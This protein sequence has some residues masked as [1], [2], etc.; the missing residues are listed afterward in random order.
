[1]IHREVRSVLHLE[2]H[3][4]I[5]ADHLDMDELCSRIA[6]HRIELNHHTEKVTKCPWCYNV[7]SDDV[8]YLQ[9]R[10][11]WSGVSTLGSLQSDGVRH[12]RPSAWW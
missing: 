6:L 2:N 10:S 11:C 1:M 4:K 9:Y 8:F 12:S 5:L 7:A 3:K